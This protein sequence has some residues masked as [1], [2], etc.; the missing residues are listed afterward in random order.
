MSE[1][2][3]DEIV[4]VRKARGCDRHSRSP[5]GKIYRAIVL[6]LDDIDI[7]RTCFMN[8]RNLL[9][10]DRQYLLLCIYNDC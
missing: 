10:M 6:P 3:G 4:H 9:G 1:I 8:A 5:K 2:R 7:E